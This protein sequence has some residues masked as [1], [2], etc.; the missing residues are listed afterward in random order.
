METLL[1][2]LMALDV[3]CIP[4]HDGIIVPR[5]K[6]NVTKAL[7]EKVWKEQRKTPSPCVKLEY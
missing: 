1:D 5:T 3:C 2:E 6:M 4:M 7:M